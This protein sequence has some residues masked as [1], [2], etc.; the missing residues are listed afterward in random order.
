[1]NVGFISLGHMGSGIE[2]PPRPV[3]PTGGSVVLTTLC[4]S[5]CLMVRLCYRSPSSSSSPSKP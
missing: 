1:M 4:R 2:D 5:Q 3:Q